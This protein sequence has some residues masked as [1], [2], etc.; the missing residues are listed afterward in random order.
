MAV[1]SFSGA[2]LI[3]HSGFVCVSFAIL[4]LNQHCYDVSYMLDDADSCP[5]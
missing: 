5:G 4:I 3:I 1:T 2:T